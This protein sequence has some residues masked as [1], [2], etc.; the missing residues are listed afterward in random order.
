LEEEFMRILA[1]HSLG[2]D[3][4]HLVVLPADAPPAAVAPVEGHLLTEI[5]VSGIQLDATKPEALEKLADTV[6]TY[7]VDVKGRGVLRKK[8]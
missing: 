8:P 4:E 2:G 5:D 6:R 1:A 7:R 3:I